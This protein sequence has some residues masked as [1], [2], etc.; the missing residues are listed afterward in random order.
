MAIKQPPGYKLYIHLLKIALINLNRHYIKILINTRKELLGIYFKKYF[1]NYFCKKYDIK[2]SISTNYLSNYYIFINSPISSI[3]PYRPSCKHKDKDDFF[4]TYEGIYDM[5]IALD[6][7]KDS[8]IIKG[9]YIFNLLAL[10]DRDGNCNYNYKLYQVKD[11][12]SPSCVSKK[13]RQEIF[14]NIMNICNLPDISSNIL[15]LSLI[16]LYDYRRLPLL[17]AL[18]LVNFIFCYKLKLFDCKCK[19][20]CTKFVLTNPGFN[21]KKEKVK[22]LSLYFRKGHEVKPKHDFINSNYTNLNLEI[23]SWDITEDF[24]SYMCQKREENFILRMIRKTEDVF[25]IWKRTLYN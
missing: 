25:Y 13:R 1:N 11:I 12:I 8:K 6:Y 5:Y 14:H 18:R 10:K 2:P 23:I 20:K 9:N 17:P 16:E 24:I 19:N 7:T 4:G 15:I 22:Y 21:I 3:N